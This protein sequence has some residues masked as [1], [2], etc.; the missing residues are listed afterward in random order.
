MN[1]QNN[2][3]IFIGPYDLLKNRHIVNVTINDI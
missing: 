1:K 3:C 2:T